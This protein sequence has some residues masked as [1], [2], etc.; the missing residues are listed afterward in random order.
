M[1]KQGALAAQRSLA[2]PVRRA[3]SSSCLPVR[4]AASV[5]RVSS[6]KGRPYSPGGFSAHRRGS[7]P[8]D[9]L[10][11]VQGLDG[12]L[13]GVQRLHKAMGQVGQ[14]VGKL[15]GS[16]G[17]RLTLGEIDDTKGWA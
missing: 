2:R 1:V 10:E 11:R 6:T 12:S 7:L 8:T 14:G 5:M 9:C 3:Q 16:F 17:F 15:S 13:V 4:P